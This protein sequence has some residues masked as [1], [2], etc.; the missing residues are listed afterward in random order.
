MTKEAPQAPARVVAALRKKFGDDAAMLM[1]ESGTGITEVCP[2]GMAVLDRWVLGVGGLPYGRIVEVSGSESSGKTTLMNKM[3]AGVQRDGGVAILC[4]TEH[5]YDPAWA[6]LHGVGVADLVLL[7]PNHLDGEKGALAQFEAAIGRHK[8]VLIAM[9]SVA[10]T[11]TKAEYEDG[12]TGGAAMAEAA[13]AW[14]RGMRILAPAIARNQAILLLV[15]QT[16]AVIGKMYGP[17]ETT[18]GGNAIKFYASIRLSVYHGKRID[19]GAGRFI[20]VQAQKN[21]VAPPFRK[22]QFKLDFAS[23][24]DD[25]WAI[26]D[27]A[28]EMGCIEA[29]CH[30]LKEAIK[31]LHWEGIEAKDGSDDKEEE[32]ET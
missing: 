10:A 29:K 24:F 16:R 8:K 12:I 19:G 23:G 17:S 21:K 28:K 20:G 7:Q 15:N 4:E 6:K 14:S 27:H 13:R 1:G 18:P 25:R 3:L 32:T 22:A 5:S 2:T 31:G 9:D 26:L 30:S 11:M